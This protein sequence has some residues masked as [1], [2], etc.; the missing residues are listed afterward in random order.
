MKLILRWILN[1]VALM[2]IPEVIAGIHVDSYSAAL[3][4]AVLLVLV[5]L[6]VFLPLFG[7]S[8]LL[9][10]ENEL[11]LSTSLPMTMRRASRAWQ[12]AVSRALPPS[13]L[14]VFQRNW[15]YHGPMP[16]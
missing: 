10:V 4:S 9:F 11:T 5:V 15:P 7:V 14:P 1:A 13:F 8:L 3:I 12:P 2:L 16:W 6:G